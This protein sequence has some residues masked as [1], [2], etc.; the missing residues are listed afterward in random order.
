MMFGW[1]KKKCEAC[2][3][4]ERFEAQRKEDEQNKIIFEREANKFRKKCREYFE[5]LSEPYGWIT[6]HNFNPLYVYADTSYMREMWEEKI[7]FTR[8]DKEKIYAEE[9]LA[10][11]KAEKQKAVLARKRE[12]KIKACYL[13]LQTQKRDSHDNSVIQN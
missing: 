7:I 5:N 4:R 10:W 2:E 13:N 3:A 11:G 9:K 1:L 8:A 12:K 6:A